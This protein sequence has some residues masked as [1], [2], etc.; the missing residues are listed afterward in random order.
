MR[1]CARL[2]RPS[3]I[4]RPVVPASPF[5]PGR[6]S[7]CRRRGDGRADQGQQGSRRFRRGGQAPG[8]HRLRVRLLHRVYTAVAHNDSARQLMQ[9][10]KLR[11][12]AVVLPSGRIEVLITSLLDMASST[13]CTSKALPASCLMPSNRTSTPRCWWPTSLRRSAKW[14]TSNSTRPRRRTT[15]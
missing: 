10:D 4:D 15:E 12:L 8:A 6:R 13:G 7:D 3:S 5:Q 14:R 2:L 1:P 9:Q 11:E